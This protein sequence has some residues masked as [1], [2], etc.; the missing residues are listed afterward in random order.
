MIIVNKLK[1]QN[2]IKNLI[3]DIDGTITR[4][5]DVGLFLRKALEKLDIPYREESL[6]GLYKAMEMREFHAMTTSES[7]EDIYGYFLELFIEDL[8]KHNVSG[9]KLKDV[10]FEMEASETFIS[11]EVPEE[12]KILSEEYEMYCYTNWFRNQALKK[13]ERYDLKDYFKKIYSSEDTYVKFSIVS[14][15]YLSY[16]H[17]LLP[18]ETVCIGDSKNDIIPSHK[19][20]FNTIY[21]DYGLT[22]DIE[23][24]PKQI[25]LIETADS[26]VTQF[27]DIRKVLAKH[28]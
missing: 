17:D 1:E 15:M 25:K 26:T 7:D 21:L 23:R 20:G 19:F 24:T 13:L 6:I 22:P 11:P 16:K 3:L 2:K 10:M 18:K 28:F 27:S 9:A 8:K 14:F 4:W 12:L 5:K